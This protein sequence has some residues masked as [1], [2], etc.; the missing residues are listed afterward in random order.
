MDSKELLEVV[1]DGAAQEESRP[2]ISPEEYKELIGLRQKT[3][4]LK[5]QKSD[6]QDFVI[7]AQQYSS[8]LPAAQE[9]LQAL[10]NQINET[11]SELQSRLKE[12]AEPH[13][14]SG[15]FSISDTEPHYINVVQPAPEASEESA[16]KP[17]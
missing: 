5:A 4:E 3:L 14:I 6:V 17:A 12:L 16:E 13:G 7:V 9:Q 1:S 8:Q 15:E 2:Q 11:A 10:V